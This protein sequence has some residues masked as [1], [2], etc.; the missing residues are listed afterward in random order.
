[1]RAVRNPDGP[2]AVVQV[3]A[4]SHE[5]VRIRVRAVGICG[6]DLHLVAMGPLP[7]TIGHEFAGVTDDGAAV[8]VRPYAACGTCEACRSGRRQ[9]CPDVFG[10]MYG[11][12]RDGAMADEIVVDPQCV[13]PLPEG[14]ELDQ[15][16]LVEPL[17]V[18]VHGVHRG[19]VVAGQRVLVVGGGP[20]GLCAVA[21]ARHLGADVDLVDTLDARQARAE[22]LGAGVGQ[23]GRYD[24]VVDAAGTSSS[25]ERAVSAARPGGTIALVGTHWAPATVPMALQMKEVT[26][27]PAITY[28]EH[29]GVDEFQTALD[30]LRGTPS[31]ADT[32]LTHRF[33]LDDA[34]EAFALAAD[35]EAG[36]VKVT[37]F[38]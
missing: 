34:V 10:H 5:G 14:V 11:V 26:V 33:G 6:S 13:V 30:V 2:V 19:A 27:V 32:L 18:A 3:P 9:Q 24:V 38:P 12:S 7:V 23:H 25:L 35:P 31:L 28:G 20:I 15:A 29:E 37:L 4:P 36:A 8:T 16:S 22:A 1:M 17:A 21:A